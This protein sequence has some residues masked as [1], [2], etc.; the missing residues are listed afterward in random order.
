ML[1]IPSLNIFKLKRNQ[2][3]HYEERYGHENIISLA[4][5][6]GELRKENWHNSPENILLKTAHE[7]NII[8]T[9]PATINELNEED[10]KNLEFFQVLC[11]L[12]DYHLE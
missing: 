1:S 2:K 4:F 5:L 10:K 6:I 8:K 11:S 12:E 3:K 7:K 9:I